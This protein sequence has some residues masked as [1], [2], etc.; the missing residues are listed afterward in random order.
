ME[1]NLRT[2]IA[3]LIVLVLAFGGMAGATTLISYYPFDSGTQFSDR[4]GDNDG[5]GIGLGSFAGIPPSVT[6]TAGEFKLGDGA[7][8]TNRGSTGSSTN[9]G[10]YVAINGL[11]N[12][13]STGTDFSLTAWFRTANIP[14]PDVNMIFGTHD[15]AGSNVYLAGLEYTGSVI[16]HVGPGITGHGD[17]GFDDDAYHFVAITH[18]S[19]TEAFTVKV[20]NVT[21]TGFPA[22]FVDWDN[23]ALVS[24]GQDFDGA[25]A[26][27]F[28]D[29]FID[30]LA[31]W[32]GELTDEDI[33]TL[34]NGGAGS[35]ATTLIPEPS[36]FVLLLLGTAGLFISARRRQR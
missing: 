36:T 16:S 29:G 5:S 7:L 6:T 30:D 26:T 32:K 27:D 2:F 3:V 1:R 24:I 19:T 9:D 12:D 33:T 23:A 35:P 18:D 22:A 8:Q 25:G 17:T 13:I 14:N 31:I 4:V 34:F 10:Q 20:D 21:Q 28:W 11:L 15:A